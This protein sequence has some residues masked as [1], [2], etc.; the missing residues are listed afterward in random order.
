MKQVRYGKKA[1]SFFSYAESGFDFTDSCCYIYLHVE[2]GLSGGGGTR[3]RDTH[4][5]KAEEQFFGR[6]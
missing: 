3:E 4:N 6:G 2:A 1:S 5:M